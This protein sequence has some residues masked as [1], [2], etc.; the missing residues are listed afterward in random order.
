M[1]INDSDDFL[2]YLVRFQNTGTAPAVN[3]IVNELLDP[4]LDWSTLQIIESSHPMSVSIANDS[5]DF[6]FYN[7]YLPDSTSDEAGS[8]GHLSY[9]I[10]SI[11]A[12]NL[13]DQVS[14]KAD[15]YFDFNAPV[16]TNTVTTT[17]VDYSNVTDVNNSF[18]SLYPNPVSD[19]IYIKSDYQVNSIKIYNQL[20][21]LITKKTNDNQLN[22]ALLKSG[23]YFCKVSDVEGN[24]SVFKVVKK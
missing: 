2:H 14:A 15:I 21:E 8:H 24:T 5:V 18:I 16:I 6:K 13:G 4:N 1:N 11:N 12:V 3:V 23:I 22:I 19:V 10:K 9:K 17:F 7:I 20:G